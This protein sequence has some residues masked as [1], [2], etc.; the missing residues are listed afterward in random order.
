MIKKGTFLNV[1]DNSGAKIAQCIHIYGGYQKKYA[2]IGDFVL[3]T[4]KSVKKKKSEDLKIK[5]GEIS[6]ALVVCSKTKGLLNNNFFFFENAVILM[7]NQNKYVGSRIF[8]PLSLS[9]RYTKFLKAVAMSS[10]IIE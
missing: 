6:K 5:K 1:V 9:F 2:K 8:V 3:I 7:T 10:G 4:V